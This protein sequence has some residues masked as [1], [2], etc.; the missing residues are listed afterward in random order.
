M[1]LRRR[2]ELSPTRKC[3]RAALL[4]IVASAA[5]ALPS[6]AA[7]AAVPQESTGAPGRWLAGDFH[8]HTCYSHDVYCG[9][10]D[11]NTGMDEIYTAGSTTQMQFCAAAARG[12]DFLTISDHNDVRSQADPGFGAC[13]VVGV[14]AYENSLEGHAQMLG[15]RVVYD[16]GDR[17]VA[18][19]RDLVGHLHADGGA[20]QVNHPAEGSVHFPHDADWG[21]GYDVLPDSVE[22]WNISRLWQPPAPSGSSNDDAVGYWEGWLDRGLA[23]AATGGSDNHWISTQAV[24]GVGQPTTW[25]YTADT[26]WSS[27]VAAVR[28]GRTFISDQPPAFGGPRLYLEADGDRDGSYESMV[29]DTV[30]PG[31]SLRVR[32]EGAPG[33]LLRVVSDG[34]QQLFAPVPVTSPAFEHSFVPPAGSTWVRAE[35]FE[36]DAS[37][38][39]SSTCDGLVGDETTYCRNQLLVRAMTSPIYLAAQRRPTNLSYIGDERARGENVRLAAELASEGVP[40]EG[41][42]LEFRIAGQALEAVTDQSGIARTVA[43]VPDHGRS[44]E[45]E[46]FFAGDR[47][48]LGSSTSAT[49]RWGSRAGE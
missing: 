7:A 47:E 43:H 37:G 28:A 18:A 41:R 5:L 15:A 10:G 39:R 26:S 35:I 9:P 40:V 31:S 3:A 16:N 2:E 17:S 6:P 29:G 19:V 38:E 27:L 4:L 1:S 25:V 22:V 34:G 24:Q 8:V 46:V 12:L 20:F 13:G 42:T 48:L 33:T 45:V 23:V 32:V 11:S 44:Q 49:V 21:Y 30:V 14:P 36:P